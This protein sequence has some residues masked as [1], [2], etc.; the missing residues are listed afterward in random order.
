LIRSVVRE[1]NGFLKGTSLNPTLFQGRQSPLAETRL[2]ER[3]G[4]LARRS[5]RPGNLRHGRS[6]RQT[7][8]QGKDQ[9]DEQDQA[10]QPA[11]RA[12]YGWPALEI[13][14]QSV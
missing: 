8:Q 11:S 5:I 6:Q 13:L 4:W 12:E 7:A 2:K 1:I 3:P 9:Q 14:I 10:N